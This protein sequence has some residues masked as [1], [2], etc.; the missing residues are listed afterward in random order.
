MLF[1]DLAC[2]LTDLCVCMSKVMEWDQHR[3]ERRLYWLDDWKP[4]PPWRKMDNEELKA[5]YDT[6]RE[7]QYIVI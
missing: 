3:M 1:F 5:R 7:Y 4:N 2:S 6:S